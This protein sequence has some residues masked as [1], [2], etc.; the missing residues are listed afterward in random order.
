MTLVLHHKEFVSA[1]LGPVWHD[2]LSRG[3]A[4]LNE[5]LLGIPKTVRH[6]LLDTY[7]NSGV[8][9]ADLPAVHTDRDRARDVVRYQW[10]GRRLWLSEHDTVEILDRGGFAGP[11]TPARVELLSD[12]LAVRFI[13]RGLALVPPSLRQ[14]KGT[15]G[16]NL[17]RTR[18]RVVTGHHRDYEEFILVY[19]L[20][21][22][23]S[24]GAETRLHDSVDPSH[25]IFRKTLSPGDLIIFRDNLFL[26]SVTP[27][28]NSA[29]GRSVR[30]ALVC[31][32][33]YPE[34]YTY[35]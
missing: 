32:V 35:L 34:T 12:P 10:A 24:G 23:G 20:D 15:F 1:R 16:I 27:L 33:N 11:R 14:Q 6:H 5:A 13:E 26:H 29:G 25:I 4:V 18:S 21:K 3:Y 31:T 19:L 30:D 22:Q 28:S 7:F 2:L 8:L 17:F 9:E